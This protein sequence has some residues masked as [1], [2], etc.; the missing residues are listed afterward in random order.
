LFLA[1][2]GHAQTAN[3]QPEDPTKVRVYFYPSPTTWGYTFKI[4]ADQTPIAKVRSKKY[5]YVADLEPGRHLLH[6][7]DV[8]HGV[9]VVLTPG[10]EYFVSCSQP[11][12][13]GTWVGRST[14]ACVLVDAEQGRSDIAKLSPKVRQ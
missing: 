3:E 1:S 4:Y 10:R 2:R 9:T 7:N 13:S 8:K 6:A 11:L 12:T 14:L 5:Y